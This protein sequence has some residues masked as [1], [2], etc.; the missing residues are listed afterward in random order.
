MPLADIRILRH[1]DENKVPEYANGTFSTIED[2]TAFAPK[3]AVIANPA[4]FHIAFGQVL[5]EAGVHLLIEKPLSSSLDGVENLIKICQERRVVLMTG[6]NLRFM[7]SLEFFKEALGKGVVGRVL[8][9]RCEVGQYLP[10]WRSDVDYRHGVSA[11]KDLGGG[12]LLELSHELDYLRWIFGE[13]KWVKATLSRQSRLDI[14]VEDTVNLT[15]GFM[16][17]VECHQLIGAVNLDFIRHDT[18]RL[19][20]AI[21]EKGS[22][23]WNYQTGE[24]MF[25]EAGASDW[26]KLYGG[27]E[28][29]DASYVAE[30]REFLECIGEDKLPL[31]S[32]YD[33][34]EVMRIIEGARQ[35]SQFDGLKFELA[36]LNE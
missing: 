20:T 13:V 5:A 31:V 21:G 30:W 35:S 24:V 7:P 2:A 16:P 4:P 6:Y 9:V 32:G 18:V 33:G 34:L 29:R 19:C 23:R 25:Y 15:L 27:K 10:S 8:S 22:L 1:K 36:D 28:Q 26:K 3:L 14:D 12:V 17:T 11:K